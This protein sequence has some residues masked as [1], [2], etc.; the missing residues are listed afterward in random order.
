MNCRLPIADY[1]LKPVEQASRLFNPASRRIGGRAV[2]RGFNVSHANSQCAR[3]WGATPQTTGA[4]PVPPEFFNRRSV[5]AFTLVELLVVISI[6][7]LI[8]ALTVP[9]LKNMGRSTLQTSASRQLLDDI[10]TARLMA[11][12]RHTTVYMVFVPTNFFNLVTSPAQGS[13]NLFTAISGMLPGADRDAALLA[14][15]NLVDKQ[16]TGYNFI[17]LGRVGDQPGQHAWHYL[18]DWKALPEGAFIASAKF[19][20]TYSYT[21]MQIPVWQNDYPAAGQI[22]NW[23]RTGVVLPQIYPF[24]NAN[25]FIPFPTEKSPS[26]MLPCLVFNHLGRLISEYDGRNGDDPS[27]YHHAYLPLA[28]GTVSYGRDAN[29]TPVLTVVKAADIT[30]NPPGNSASISYNVID[31]DPLSGRAKL[32][33]HHLP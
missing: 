25:V 16:L 29:K 6:M 23:R 27:S 26:V 5:I 19:Q 3:V 24:T 11:I 1:R 21:P 8:A 28:Q 4:T 31:V 14:L 18:D 33:V 22:D 30:E 13:Q 17:S 10:G 7:G 9:A 2:G 12:S 32:L 15:T 20:S